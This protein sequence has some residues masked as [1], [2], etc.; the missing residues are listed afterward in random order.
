MSNMTYGDLVDF[1]QQVRQQLQTSLTNLKEIKSAC[2]PLVSQSAF[3][4]EAANAISS[5]I[6]EV[7]YSIISGFEQGLQESDDKVARYVAQYAQVDGSQ[8]LEL[9]DDSLQNV[10]DLVKSQYGQMEWF[11]EDISRIMQS[12]DYI[13]TTS[14]EGQMLS[15]VEQRDEAYGNANTIVGKLRENWHA[16]EMQK[17]NEFSDIDTAI[18]SLSRLISNYAGAA[19]PEMGSYTSGGFNSL[20]GSKYFDALKSMKNFETMNAGAITTANKFIDQTLVQLVE[21]SIGSTNKE[22]LTRF[23]TDILADGIHTSVVM[24]KIEEDPDLFTYLVNIIDKCPESL[25]NVVLNSFI[26]NEKLNALPTTAIEAVATNPKFANLLDQALAKLPVAKQTEVYEKLVG[27]GDKALALTGHLAD[28]LSRTATGAKFIEATNSSLDMFKGL[29]KVSQFVK[30]NPWAGKLLAY[31]GDGL[32]IAANSYDEYKNPESKAFGNVDK[33]IYGGINKFM[34]NAGPLEMSEIGGAVG[35][36]AGPDGAAVL[37]TGGL[38]VGTGN[39]VSQ[40]VAG[41]L[42]SAAGTGSAEQNER[43]FLN[44]QYALYGKPYTPPTVVRIDPNT[45]IRGEGVTPNDPQ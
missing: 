4:G 18:S 5:Y 21:E 43:N 36:V 15:A 26:A 29:A 22:E 8:D 17:R 44:A 27:L 23:L 34:Y 11:Q 12:V 16:Y 6:E 35:M 13:V 39:T 20:A 30:D 28:V 38:I 45:T 41:A 3:T 37:G 7:H 19:S 42:E 14:G 9:R 2:A 24:T 32:V 33:A 25:Q 40:V 10:Q 1:Q 31:G